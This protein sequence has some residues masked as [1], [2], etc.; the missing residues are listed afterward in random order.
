MLLGHPHLASSFNSQLWAMQQ[1]GSCLEV[2]QVSCL[3]SSSLRQLCC[4]SHTALQ[5]YNAAEA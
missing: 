4:L 1:S 3:H 5:A 2:L